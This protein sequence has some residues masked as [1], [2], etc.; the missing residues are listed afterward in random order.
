VKRDSYKEYEEDGGEQVVVRAT[1]PK[2]EKYIV[3]VVP[4]ELG[5]SRT[6]G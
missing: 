2:G 6:G 3:S 4:R 5:W 1:E